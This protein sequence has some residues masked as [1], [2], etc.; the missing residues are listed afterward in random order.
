MA[1]EFKYELPRLPDELKHART[2]K[3]KQ[4][5]DYIK[6]LI[7]QL[8]QDFSTGLL[9]K[10]EF[11]R[12]RESEGHGVYIFIDGDGLKKIN[13]MT[14]DHGAGD[15]AIK[16]LAT[17][18]RNALRSGENIEIARMGG[19]E[20][21]V[22]V[23]NVTTSTG[24]MIGKRILDSIRNAPIEYKGSNP[25]VKE[26]IENWDLTASIGVGRTK[27]EAD[28]AMYKAKA[29][30][31][32]RVEFYSP[33]KDR[34]LAVARLIQKLCRQGKVSLAKKLVKVLKEK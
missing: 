3:E 29:N 1:D 12:R 9:H 32:N 5:L 31:R 17:G 15:A 33:N 13:D 26:I 7:T 22:F 20:F 21:V 4:Y 34:D 14:H 19:D 28:K 2:E 8:Q 16:A 30:G 10:E 18:I 25:E 24:V 23:P 27:D 6:G 11:E